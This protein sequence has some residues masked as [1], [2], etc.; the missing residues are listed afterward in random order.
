M[1]ARSRDPFD[2]GRTPRDPTAASTALV[3]GEPQILE[4]LYHEDL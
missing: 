4:D 1:Q 3:E 2:S